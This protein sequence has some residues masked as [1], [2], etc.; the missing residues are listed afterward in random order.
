MN[1]RFTILLVVI[2]VVIGG[3]VWITQR[4]PDGDTRNIKD[5]AWKVELED[6]QRI[7]ITHEDTSVAYSREGRGWVI[8]GEDGDTIPVYQPKW[9][10]KALIVSGPRPSRT[11]DETVEDPSL[12]GLE[13]VA[14]TV[15][16]TD[17]SGQQVVFEL[18]AVTPD[19]N[20]QY[21]RL[22]D[23]SLH[24]LPKI[25]GEVVVSLATRPPYT[26][27][28]ISV[29]GDEEVVEMRVQV[30]DDAT[31]I[32]AEAVYLLT[33]L[34]EGEAEAGVPEQWILVEG[35]GVLVNERWDG[36]ASGLGDAALEAGEETF[37][38]VPD[39]ESKDW[40]VRLDV[41]NRQDVELAYFVYSATS[42]PARRYFWPS[43]DETLSTVDGEWVDA[44]VTLAE[45][46]TV[47]EAP[48]GA[49]G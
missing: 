17:R 31:D 48:P 6:L 42:D 16:V 8:E 49:T 19:G 34:G 15:G 5:W 13:P 38:S 44:L 41:R 22:D 25:W 29:L 28:F 47:N 43:G 21:V 20:N 2:L 9:G 30:R 10:G 3:T 37:E 12:Y 32:T 18:G 36:L 45:E 40:T 35:A 33:G 14:T 11:L 27:P 23:N 46:P 1:I 24:T 7:A 26:P 4:E 39:F